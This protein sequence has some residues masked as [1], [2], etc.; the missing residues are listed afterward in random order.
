[1][2][3]LIVDDDRL[4]RTPGRALASAGYGTNC[5][6]AREKTKEILKS[7]EPVI[8]SLAKL[9]VL[10][11]TSLDPK[12]CYEAADGLGISGHVVK[13]LNP[14]ELLECVGLCWIR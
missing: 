7:G 1:V 4:I 14:Q 5:A 9:P 8:S 11:Y 2:K 13:P 10:V 3:I 6:R 12:T